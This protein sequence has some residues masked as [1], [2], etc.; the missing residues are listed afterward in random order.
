M[1]KVKGYSKWGKSAQMGY[2]STLG[3]KM[4]MY[5]YVNCYR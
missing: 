2:W 5:E 1:I 4:L 3:L